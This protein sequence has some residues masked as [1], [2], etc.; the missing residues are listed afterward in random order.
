MSG[1]WEVSKIREK[2]LAGVR[3]LETATYIAGPYCCTL[4]AEFGAEVIKIEL[5]G[6][7][8]PGRYYGTKSA[9]ED[10]TFRRTRE[11]PQVSR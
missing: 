7:G 1:S 2:P 3:V 5:P 8:E 9:A 11:S 10:A 4:M 6:V